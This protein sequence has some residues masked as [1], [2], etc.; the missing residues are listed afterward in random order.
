MDGL[1]YDITALVGIC[2]IPEPDD[3][4]DNVSNKSSDDKVVAPP[5][6]KSEEDYEDRGFWDPNSRNISQQKEFFVVRRAL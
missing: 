5:H 2:L 4:T 6:E 1:L 3:S